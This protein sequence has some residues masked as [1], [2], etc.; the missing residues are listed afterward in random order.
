M[1]LGLIASLVTADL[2]QASG[3]RWIKLGGY[4]GTPVAELDTFG[5]DNDGQSDPYGFEDASTVGFDLEG[6]TSGVNYRYTWTLKKNSTGSKILTPGMDVDKGNKVAARFQVYDPSFQKL[7]WIR[8]MGAN[9]TDL[10]I[11]YSLTVESYPYVEFEVETVSPVATASDFDPWNA[12]LCVE[13]NYDFAGDG[14]EDMGQTVVVTNARPVDL[15]DPAHPS[16]SLGLGVAFDFGGMQG[17]E[18]RFEYFA[19][20]SYADRWSLGLDDYQG[21]I[22]GRTPPDGNFSYENLGDPATL[23]TTIDLDT[24]VVGEAYGKYEVKYSGWDG[25][26]DVQFG[27][28]FAPRDSDSDGLPN[29]WEDLY[30]FNKNVADTPL[31]SDKDDDG[32]LDYFEFLAGTD[33]CDPNS[34]LQFSSTNFD[35]GTLNFTLEW[36]SVPGK[37]YDLNYLPM[38]SMNWMPLPGGQDIPASAGST[39]SFTH[40]NAPATGGD[41]ALYNAALSVSF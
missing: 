38:G 31:L 9:L 11:D 1:I 35:P 7:S 37:V 16:S 3:C 5:F 34:R 28:H 8:I 13:F 20:A 4:L 41:A 22:N 32:F 27:I 14:I 33:P 19:S 10:K 15:N 24:G 40:T 6:F 18:T 39:T 30:T 26:D 29:D 2:C 21:A 17:V 23:G 36:D 25:T 12:G